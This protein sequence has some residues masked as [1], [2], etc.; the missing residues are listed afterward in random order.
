VQ[1][2]VNKDQIPHG[3]G[4]IAHKSKKTP[5]TRRGESCPPSMNLLG[6]IK[7]KLMVGIQGQRKDPTTIVWFGLQNKKP[8]STS[9]GNGILGKILRGI[10][11]ERVG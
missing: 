6:V 2:K 5:E 11:R 7:K 1:E 8:S 4:S 9:S 3:R 10:G